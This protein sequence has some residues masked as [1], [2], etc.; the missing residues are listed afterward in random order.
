MASPRLVPLAMAFLILLVAH[1]HVSNAHILLTPG[2]AVPAEQLQAEEDS[3]RLRRASVADQEATDAYS[4]VDNEVTE[5]EVDELIRDEAAKELKGSM[6]QPPRRL[7]S[8][9]KRDARRRLRQHRLRSRSVNPHARNLDGLRF[10]RAP[11]G[12]DDNDN[13]KHEDG[14]PAHA[15]DA[16]TSTPLPPVAKAEPRKRLLLTKRLGARALAHGKG[17]AGPPRFRGAFSRIG[18]ESGGTDL[19]SS[20][21][22]TSAPLWLRFLRVGHRVGSLPL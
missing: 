1:L 6:L 2:H 8:T 9:D 20:S 18:A 16:Q 21:D 7:L 22:Q 14:A 11:G 3:R 15:G 19:S 10:A 13:D 17:N 12:H 5:E 4:A